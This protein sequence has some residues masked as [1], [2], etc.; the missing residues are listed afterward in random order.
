MPAKVI[1]FIVI[2]FI[3][4]TSTSIISAASTSQP[5]F[6]Q[7]PTC[8]VSYDLG[9]AETNEKKALIASMFAAK[10]Y[11]LNDGKPD[12]LEMEI[13]PDGTTGFFSLTILQSASLS[14]RRKGEIYYRKYGSGPGN[15]LDEIRSTYLTFATEVLSEIPVC[16][17]AI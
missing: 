12:A 3:L 4:V 14:H 5:E 15:N 8:S 11:R 1:T 7:H 6:I 9:N 10:G 17:P 13:A 16:K 2:A